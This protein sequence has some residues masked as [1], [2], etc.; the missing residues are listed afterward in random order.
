MPGPYVGSLRGS[1]EAPVIPV[2]EPSR[3]SSSASKMSSRDRLR[4]AMHP[5][6]GVG[7]MDDIERLLKASEGVGIPGVAAG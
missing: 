2:I 1:S 6:E 4:P 7:G 5:A 3:G